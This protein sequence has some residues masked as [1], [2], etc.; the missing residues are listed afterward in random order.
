VEKRYDRLAWRHLGMRHDP[1]TIERRVGTMLRRQP[2]PVPVPRLVGADRRRRVLRFEAV[3]GDDLG[4]KFPLQLARGDVADLV[5]LALAL[6]RYRPHAPFLG[7]F[8]LSRRIAQ[9]VSAEHLAP[10]AGSAFLRQAREDP[11]EVVFGHGD[12][13]A[14]NVMRSA[15]G[16]AV[17][18]DWEWAG[19]YPR[20]WDLA[21]LWFTLVDVEG[22]RAAVEA[23]IPHADVA[24]FWRSALLVQL[25]HLSLNG[26][27]PGTP[28]RAKHE[29]MRDE[30]LDRVL[31]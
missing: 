30:L 4:P 17:L 6:P 31:G 22:A 21:F 27:A 16:E 18:I 14:R 3:D 7:R 11:P 28:F 20:G 23:A 19:R 26:L 24:W 29:R 12:I 1:W 10:A 2:P 13:T 9:A 25:L 5:A 8:D 15:A